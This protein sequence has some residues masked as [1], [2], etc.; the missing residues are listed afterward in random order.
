[1]IV[2]CRGWPES[3]PGA[4]EARL[5]RLRA[6]GCLLAPRLG[7]AV[8]ES[9]PRGCTPILGPIGVAGV[10]GVGEVIGPTSAAGPLPAAERIRP[11]LLDRG[12]LLQDG[13]ELPARV[14]TL[15]ELL[16]VVPREHAPSV[17]SGTG[18]SPLWCRHL[19]PGPRARLVDRRDWSTAVLSQWRS[20]GLPEVFFPT[21][22][23]PRPQVAPPAADRHAMRRHRPRSAG[24][25]ARQHEE[26]NHHGDLK[27]FLTTERT[28][29]T[30]KD[31]E[32]IRAVITE[33]NSQKNVYL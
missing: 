13:P 30:E 28:E 1:M 19:P 23:G 9:A 33:A 18:V 5:G 27:T 7:P 3:W 20:V 10:Y 12:R 17:R 14:A 16:L 24:P 11:D 6:P 15:D 29:D 26:E 2:Q 4:C 31:A 21:R 25:P 22:K 8:G 32:I